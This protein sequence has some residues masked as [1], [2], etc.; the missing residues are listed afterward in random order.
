MTNF[1]DIIDPED[2]ADILLEASGKQIKEEVTI[3]SLLVGT[4]IK[5]RYLPASA[6]SNFQY[7]D[8]QQIHADSNPKFKYKKNMGELIRK[9]NDLC[10][11]NIKIIDDLSFPD[12]V[13]QRGEVRFSHIAPG[14]WTR[15]RELCFPGAQFDTPD[16]ED[17]DNVPDRKNSKGLR[18][19][20]TPVSE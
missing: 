1:E 4:K 7:D 8:G 12:H 14:E 20:A 16:S 10:L 5:V 11:K 17:P 3:L 6:A 13:F 19:D 18:K 2:N 9:I 15:L